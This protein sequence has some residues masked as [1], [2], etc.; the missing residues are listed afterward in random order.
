MVTSMLSLKD[1]EIIEKEYGEKFYTTIKNFTIKE[2]D[3]NEEKIYDS[4]LDIDRFHIKLRKLI[5]KYYKTGDSIVKINFNS[6]IVEY[7]LSTLLCT[8]YPMYKDLII[9]HIEL[10][11]DIY[12]ESLNNLAKALRTKKGIEIITHK[13]YTNVIIDYIGTLE[14]FDGEILSSQV[15]DN[16]IKIILRGR[17]DRYDFARYLLTNHTPTY[18]LFKFT[19]LPF[20]R[21]GNMMD[22][23]VSLFKYGE[24]LYS[25]TPLY[26][27]IILSEINSSEIDDSEM[28]ELEY[29]LYHKEVELNGSTI[30]LYRECYSGTDD[31][32]CYEFVTLEPIVESPID[33]FLVSRVLE[34]KAIVDLCY[35]LV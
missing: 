30:H 35:N 34:Y 24:Y 33:G 16:Y 19:M 6:K 9:S 29:N 10:Q 8:L 14:S 15:N 11:D 13:D 20:V 3:L 18:S 22:I 5:G 31:P 23:D 28:D 27:D 21:L 1:Y 32:G 2:Y 12:Y 4:E 25:I 17:I 7:D 26:Q